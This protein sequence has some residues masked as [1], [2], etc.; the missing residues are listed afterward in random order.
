MAQPQTTEAQLRQQA[1]TVV[2]AEH[3]A[4]ERE[5]GHNICMAP[6]HND[7]YFDDEDAACD[8]FEM[9]VAGAVTALVAMGKKE[10]ETTEARWLKARELVATEVSPCARTQGE[11][12]CDVHN[13]SYW[14]ADDAACDQVKMIVV[15]AVIG[16]AANHQHDE[17]SDAIW[18]VVHKPTGRTLCGQPRDE[19]KPV[20]GRP[21][22]EC[23]SA[24]YD[25]FG[26]L[27]D[28]LEV[29]RR[30][31]SR[32]KATEARVEVLRAA[33]NIALN[34][35]DPQALEGAR[36]AL[37]EVREED[38]ELLVERDRLRL[39]L[40]QA[41]VEMARIETA[42]EPGYTCTCQVGGVDAMSIDTDW[43]RETARRARGA[44]AGERVTPVAGMDMVLVE[45]TRNNPEAVLHQLHR[46]GVLHRQTRRLKKGG[47]REGR[48]AT[49]EPDGRVE[50]GE[51]LAS[52]W[53]EI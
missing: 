49:V 27:L 48:Y 7:S 2:T 37:Q 19:V 14:H 13:N 42:T 25:V 21:C 41:D 51:G 20:Q 50:D 47:P 52:Q 38:L 23:A 22:P 35:D 18:H 3:G 17:K 44:L 29:M 4:C 6:T 15:G 28:E 33:L 12:I 30:R 5:D 34:S 8:Q 16:L 1:R 9:L 43:L 45:H 31:V 32:T 10:T 46:A 26:D 39:R 11:T 24:M 53:E 36:M 40:Q